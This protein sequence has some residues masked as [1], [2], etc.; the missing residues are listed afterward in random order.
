MISFNEVIET[1]E[2]CF[3]QAWE[4][5]EASVVTYDSFLNCKSEKSDRDF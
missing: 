1:P 3:N 4:M 2:F 5:L